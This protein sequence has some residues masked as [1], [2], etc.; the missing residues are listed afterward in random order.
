MV[1]ENCVQWPSVALAAWRLIS[2]MRQAAAIKRLTGD[3]NSS[4]RR[5][6]TAKK[7]WREKRESVMAAA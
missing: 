4:A 6:Q 2:C 3:G 1:A 7:A 5:H